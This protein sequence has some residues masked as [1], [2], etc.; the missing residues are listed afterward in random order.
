MWFRKVVAV[1]LLIAATVLLGRYVADRW[2]SQE[3]RFLTAEEFFGE[4]LLRQIEELGIPV[5][6]HT[7]LMQEMY[8]G[9]SGRRAEEM[10][11]DVTYDMCTLPAELTLHFQY[12]EFVPD[13]IPSLQPRDSSVD[14]AAVHALDEPC[15]ND[16][17]LSMVQHTPPE[18]EEPVGYGRTIEMEIE[19]FPW[20]RSWQSTY[21]LTLILTDQ[22]ELFRAIVREEWEV[23]TPWGRLIAQLEQDPDPSDGEREIGYF[24]FP[25]QLG[26]AY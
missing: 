26:V 20:D 25:L 19:G 18:E 14:L 22:G 12:R 11:G 17:V 24:N 21:Y 10:V 3:G 5:A 4:E 1:L 16:L 9:L 6:T 8:D 23:I 7:A 2:A 13:T 15:S